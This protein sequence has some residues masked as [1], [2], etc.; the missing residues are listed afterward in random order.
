MKLLK[1]GFVFFLHVVFITFAHVNC[2]TWNAYRSAYETIYNH[3]YNNGTSLI[4]IVP[5]VNQSN[6]MTVQMGL[7]LNSLNGFDAVLGQIDISGSMKLQW[8]D[9]VVF[10]TYT[11]LAGNSLDAILIDY[12]KA[13][14]PSL[15]LVNAVDT[16]KNIGDTTYKLMYN[17]DDQ[18]VKW[19]PRILLRG[20]CTPDVTY[21]PFDRQVCDFTYTAWGYMSEEIRL[22]IM[23]TEWDMS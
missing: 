20:S 11:S 2:Q 15:V 8:T 1:N 22:Q 12:D 19:E 7:A 6:P 4:D 16:V 14:S 5:I 18:T 17:P 23:T 9:E 21:Y 10:T 13:W 3:Y